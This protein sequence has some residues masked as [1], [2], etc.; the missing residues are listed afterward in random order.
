MGTSA[1][2]PNIVLATLF[3]TETQSVFFSH[4]MPGYNCYSQNPIYHYMHPLSMHN[5]TDSPVNIDIVSD[6][7]EKDGIRVILEWT[8][9][10]HTSYSY[11]VSVTPHPAST[12]IS[13]RM[14][15]ELKV[16]YDLLYNVSVLATPHC[17]GQGSIVEAFIELYHGQYMY[18]LRVHVWN[19]YIFKGT[20]QQGIKDRV[21]RC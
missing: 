18:R 12:L 21:T 7:F 15:V 1:A 6:N 16:S 4:C 17:T 9:E 10:N 3:P 5:H 8:Q 11:N 20:P 2:L 14:R 19:N 13:E